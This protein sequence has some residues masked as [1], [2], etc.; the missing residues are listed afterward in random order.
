MVLVVRLAG[1]RTLS[2]FLI[3]ASA[4]VPSGDYSGASHGRLAMCS[5]GIP[6]HGKPTDRVALTGLYPLK[7]AP[8]E[9]SA[10]RGVILLAA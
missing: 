10:D 8:F 9:A 6:D 7:Q 3:P 4:T 5:R 2:L 1:C